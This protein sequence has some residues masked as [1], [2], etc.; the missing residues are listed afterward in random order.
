MR[1]N[2]TEIGVFLTSKPPDWEGRL[3]YKPPK[4][5]GAWSLEPVFKERYFK[6]LGN[7][8]YCL[9]LGP[10]SKGQTSDPVMV[11]VLE[12]FTVTP[13]RQTADGSDLNTF[14]ITFRGEESGSSVGDKKHVFVAD[15][16]RTVT[17][18]TEVNTRTRRYTQRRNY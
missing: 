4:S 1:W 8:L 14:S 7:L 9:R 10:Y 16:G 11:L 12:N 2:E 13:S 15:S 3:C 18:W 17:Q 5:S 6:L